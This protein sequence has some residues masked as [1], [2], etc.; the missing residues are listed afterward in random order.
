M[1]TDLWTAF[2]KRDFTTPLDFP[3]VKIHPLSYSW[4]AMGGPKQYQFSAF[5]DANELWSMLNWLRAP[6][7]L[8]DSRGEKV[9]WGYASEIVVRLGAVNFGLSLDTMSNSVSITYTEATLEKKTSAASNARSVATYGTKELVSALTNVTVTGA[10][11][12]RDVLLEM[13]KYPVPS[14]D[15]VSGIRGAM[16]VSVLCKGWWDTLRWKYYDDLNGKEGYTDEAG[17]D[18][19]EVGTVN[20]EKVTQTFQ[21]GAAWSA[22]GSVRVKIGKTG[23]PTDDVLIEICAD[24]S[25]VPGTALYTFTLA[26]ADIS[27]GVDWVELQAS[28]STALTASTTYH[29]V[30][31]R[32]GSVSATDHYQF[33]AN[34]GLGYAD[35]SLSG[36]KPSTWTA[37]SADML[38]EIAGL[39]QS[40][41][42]ILAMLTDCGQFMTGSKLETASG[43]NTLSY[44]DGNGT[45]LEEIEGLL[46]IGTTSDRRLLA[47]VTP[48][49]VVRIYQ[50]PAWNAELPDYLVTDQGVWL[51][52]FGQQIQQHICP[53]A[54]WATLKD[55]I[56]A[57][58]NS[59]LM[60][61]ASHF[62]VEEN[63]YTIST[64]SLRPTPR[65]VGNVWDMG[66]VDI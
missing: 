30:I 26:S 64:Q 49:R 32:S 57:V 53:V 41:T 62:F 17:E 2:Y 36:Y 4:A 40:S 34:P 60:A 13:L 63:E 25:G 22:V 18:D 14:V 48:G 15:I 66:A 38:F 54:K 6:V 19:Y 47:T 46:R 11:N 10:E 21:T 45:A 39:V 35:G 58:V 24:S 1:K 27:E 50:E 12:K 3:G 55:V 29:L 56:P 8:S 23:A 28:G 20:V 44:R 43:V 33:S 31:R 59:T 7:E 5:G 65:A 37:I 42:Q 9:W 52:I 51:N 61:D 16:S